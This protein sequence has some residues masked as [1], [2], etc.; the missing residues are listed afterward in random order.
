M[1]QFFLNG[2]V[3]M[4]GV[5]VC[6]LGALVAAV[7]FAITPDQRKIGAIISLS[8]A[9]TASSLLGMISDAATVFHADW[10]GLQSDQRLASGL[11]ITVNIGDG[12]NTGIEAEATWR[13]DTHLQVRTNL[14][15]EEPQITRAADV[16]PARRDIGLP[17][18][19]GAMGATDV[20][21]RWQIGRFHA[22]ASAQVSYVGRSFLTFDGG[23][24]N[25]MGGYASG[26]V[27]AALG[28]GAWQV[29]AYID[30]F[31]DE[32][33]NTFAF[34][35][36]FSRARA[37]QATPLRPRTIGLGFARDF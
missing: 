26:R 16:F 24:G 6:G 14:L 20:R 5:V 10:R 15:L 7:R 33:G 19:P 29:T 27:A 8:L 4:L 3:P 31:A 25:A 18:V 12:S 21:Y 34:G 28:A 23:L 1:L 13:P 11:P 17:G 22:E 32:R 2:G 30:N 35:N 37:T 9:T 36:P